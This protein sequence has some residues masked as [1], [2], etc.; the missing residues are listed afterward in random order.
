MEMVN[1][2]EIFGGILGHAMDHVALT[3]GEQAAHHLFFE[4]YDH[5][6]TFL[7]REA[8]SDAVQA[9]WKSIADRQ[10]GHLEQLM[11]S[12]GF[13]GME[14]YWRATLGQEG[15]DFE[16]NVND[17]MFQ[18]RVKRCPPNEWFKSRSI[19]KYPRYCEHC[20]VL[21]QRV[22]ERCGFAMEYFAPDEQAGVCCGFRFT[23]KGLDGRKE[24]GIA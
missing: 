17:D 5:V 13:R 15:A 7:D 18:L 22:G 21:Y 23:R 14:E 11:R 10:L 16:M 9:L 20:R 1:I 8:G 2:S 6:F 4:L 12:K 3:H 19:A 24:Y